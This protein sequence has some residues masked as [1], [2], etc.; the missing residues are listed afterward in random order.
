MCLKFELRKV[1]KDV[2]NYVFIEINGNKNYRKRFR[3]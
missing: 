2:E 1:E 3:K